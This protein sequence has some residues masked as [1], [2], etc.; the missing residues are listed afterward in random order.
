MHETLRDMG[1][2]IGCVTNSIRETATL[3][4][5]KTGQYDFMQ[6]LITN[7]DVTKPKPDSE[8]YRKAM[9]EFDVQPEE[10]LIIEDSEKGYIAATNSKAYVLKVKDFTEV[11]LKSVLDKIKL[12]S[13]E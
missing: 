3:M 8:C 6:I 9:E 12:I 4:L 5:S 11:N 7:E 13:G 10:T 1:F 2:V